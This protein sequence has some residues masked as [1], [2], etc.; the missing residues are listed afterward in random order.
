MVEDGAASVSTSFWIDGPVATVNIV[1]ATPGPPVLTRMGPAYRGSVMGVLAGS[2][3]IA[4][5]AVPG[6]EFQ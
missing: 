1:L 2:M 4:R 6:V 5:T 3:V